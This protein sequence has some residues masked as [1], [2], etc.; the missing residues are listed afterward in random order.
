MIIEKGGKNGA[1]PPSYDHQI[2]TPGETIYNKNAVYA[3][4]L[5]DG[6]RRDAEPPGAFENRRSAPLDLVPAPA[7]DWAASFCC[8]SR[9]SVM[10]PARMARFP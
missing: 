5:C 8:E 10:R 6:D 7:S 9:K 2:S 3:G 1:R 4:L